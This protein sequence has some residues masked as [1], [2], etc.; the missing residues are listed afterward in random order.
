MRFLIIQGN[1]SGSVTPKLLIV[2]MLLYSVSA[3]NTGKAVLAGGCLAGIGAL[4]FYG[5]GLSNELGAIDKARLEV[6]MV[7]C[8]TL[9]LL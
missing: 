4:C 9:S 3:E 7:H 5:L 2:L 1:L 6:W 8:H